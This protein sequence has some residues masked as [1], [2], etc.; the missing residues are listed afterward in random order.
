[1]VQYNLLYYKESSVINLIKAITVHH[2]RKLNCSNTCKMIDFVITPFY[3]DFT[4]TS[5]LHLGNIKLL[6]LLLL[7]RPIF[8]VVLIQNV[9]IL[10]ILK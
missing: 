8:Q 6:L 1:M 2:Q 10:I 5:L 9:Y 7:W 4:D 3:R